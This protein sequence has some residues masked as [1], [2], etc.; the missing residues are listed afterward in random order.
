MP[1][2]VLCPFDHHG[3]ASGHDDLILAAR[4]RLEDGVEVGQV[5]TGLIHAHPDLHPVLLVKM[6]GD[7]SGEN[8]EVIKKLVHQRLPTTRRAEAEALWKAAEMIWSGQMNPI[9]SEF[10][11]NA[12]GQEA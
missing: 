8:L 10:G 1:V 6:V 11:I 9:G 5:V 7:A 2:C 12:G 4:T 3:G